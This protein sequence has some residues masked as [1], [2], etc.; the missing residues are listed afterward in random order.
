MRSGLMHM[1]VPYGQFAERAAE[2]KLGNGFWSKLFGDPQRLLRQNAGL[3]PHGVNVTP[4]LQ[5][6][7]PELRADRLAQ[8][9][10]R[11]P[12]YP[13]P[14]FPRQVV[15]SV[16][17]QA[18]P[19]DWMPS[20]YSQTYQPSTSVISKRLE[21]AKVEM[22]NPDNYSG[23][24]WTDSKTRSYL[25]SGAGERSL[26]TA[27]SPAT[28]RHELGHH[29]ADLLSVQPRVTR[30]YSVARQLSRH[31]PRGVNSFIDLLNRSPQTNASEITGHYM[32]TRNYQSPAV[33]AM[34]N[35]V[36]K[37]IQAHLERNYGWPKI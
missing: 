33:A 8:R 11:V 16:N 10:Q 13:D 30:F 20:L 9:S 7:A 35:P 12:L 3:A 34:P 37:S 6:M 28:M 24:G 27:G 29:V 14:N 32:A 21:A 15:N 25:Q 5:K 36:L 4:I 31:D 1:F 2:A 18:R 23:T 22:R 19:Q 17:M 26:I